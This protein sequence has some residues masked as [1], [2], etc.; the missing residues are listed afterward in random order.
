MA[1]ESRPRCLKRNTV[2]NGCGEVNRIEPIRYDGVMAS[3]IT[4]RESNTDGESEGERGN[5]RT[6]R[7]SPFGVQGEAL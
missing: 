1:R 3:S 7:R 2:H 4:R 6:S 5:G